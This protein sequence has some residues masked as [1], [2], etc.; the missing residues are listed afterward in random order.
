M[1]LGPDPD[2]TCGH[3][4]AEAMRPIAGANVDMQAIRNNLNAL[5]LAVFR[6][7]TVNADTKSTSAEDGAFWT[8]IAEMQAWA[9]GMEQWRI[10]VGAGST[11]TP[12]PPASAPTSLTGGI[13]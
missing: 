6:I 10:E 7:A 9:E 12:P 4:F 13:E 1:P 8:W 3:E 5:G 2:V 11:L